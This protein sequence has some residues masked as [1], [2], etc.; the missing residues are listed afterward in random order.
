MASP[1][2]INATVAPAGNAQVVSSKPALL[3]G[4]Y[5]SA[6]GGNASL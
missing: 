5:L 4:G 2:T 6:V 3:N 1:F